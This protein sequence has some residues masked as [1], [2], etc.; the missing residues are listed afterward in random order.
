[1]SKLIDGLIEIA[2]NNYFRYDDSK[3]YNVVVS[4]VLRWALMMTYEI[5]VKEG[6]IEPI[7][8]IEDEKKN[9][10]WLISGCFSSDSKIKI[11]QSK[12]LYTLEQI[13][14]TY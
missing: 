3:K 14:S 4:S 1:M 10:Y 8:N 6:E 5:L 13:T 11:E 9:K 12:S 7:E 2:V